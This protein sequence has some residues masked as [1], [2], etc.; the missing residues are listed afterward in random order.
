MEYRDERDL[1]IYTD[2]SSFASPRR[3]GVGILYVVV[4]ASGDERVEEFPRPGYAGATNN[5]MELLAAIEAL[6]ALVTRRAP[7]E[8]K[9]FA[10]WLSGATRCISW[11]GTQA[12][13]LH[14][15]ATAG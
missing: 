13:A 3:G 12:R 8:R 7:V 2:G 11:K 10:R 1:N 6:K 14:G 4:D 5:Q 15:P 9:R